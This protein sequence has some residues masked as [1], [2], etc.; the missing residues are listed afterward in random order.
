MRSHLELSR[1]GE[2]SAGVAR[3]IALDQVQSDGSL[4]T[5]P[6]DVAVHAR[7]QAVPT[8]HRVQLNAKT[9]AFTI[10]VASEPADVRLDPNLW[11]LMEA[12]FEIQPL[13]DYTGDL[14]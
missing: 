1:L 14:P 10:D 4:F 2:R 6:M 13:S 5:M 11:V 3:R 8:I 12:T 9:N 7:G